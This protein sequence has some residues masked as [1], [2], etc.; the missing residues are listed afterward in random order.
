MNSSAVRIRSK[1]TV[2]RNVVRLDD[3]DPLPFVGTQTVSHAEN[4]P[5]VTSVELDAGRDKFPVELRRYSTG[6]VE[7]EVLPV[8]PDDHAVER[9][10]AKICRGKE[11]R[12]NRSRAND[13]D[14]ALRCDRA[15]HRMARTQG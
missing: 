13:R 15:T 4:S 8:E 12:N 2:P 3:G 9:G 6:A 14:G 10:G 11:R 1:I 5:R 7:R